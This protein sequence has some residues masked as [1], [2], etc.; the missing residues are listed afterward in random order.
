M[1]ILFATTCLTPLALLALSAPAR[2]ETLIETKRTDAVTTA[3]IKAGAPDDIRITAAGGLAP[4]SGTA[5]TINSNNKVSNQGAIQI[6]GANNANGILALAGTSGA[7]ASSGS[8]TIDET[9]VAVDTDKDG[10]L[11]GSFAT[12]TRR[13]GIRTAGA[14]TGSIA[15]TGT[16]T[17]E[18]N[19]SA[20]I[21]LGG[22]LTGSLETG[23]AITVTGDR[24]VGV[25]AGAVSGNVRLAGAITA[26]GLG[27]TGAALNG[28]IGGALVV[29]GSIVATGYRS[30]T[31]P[32]DVSKLDGDDLL[33][34]GPAL[35]IAGNVAGGVILAVPPRDLD[36]KEADEDK[37]GIPDA[38][39]GSAAITSHGAAAAVQIGATDRAITIGPV[40][41]STFGFVIDGNVAG[42]GVY[43]GVDARGLV[44]GGLGGAVT[45]AGGIAVN[46]NVKAVS[47]DSNATA[48]RIGS[49]ATAPEVRV[50]G[51]IEASGGGKAGATSTAIAVDS[52]ATVTTIRNSGMIKAGA[53]AAEGA[54]TAIVDRSGNLALVE[55]SGVIG[56][57]GAAAGRNI[58]IDLRANTTGAI[59]RQ[60]AGA[61]GAAAPS[62]TGDIYFGSGADTL[63]LGG[64]SSFTGNADF[65]GGAD[66]L[67]LTGGSRFTGS[68]AGAQGLA[69]SVGSGTLALT[70]KSSV[71][72]ASLA[73]GS[74]GVIGVNID[75]AGK[76]NT[77]FDVAGTA[78][79]DKG[80]QVA[81][82]LANVSNAEGKYVIVRAGALSGAA[83]LGTSATL[84]PF[85][86]KSS[87]AAGAPGE[88]VLDLARKSA[89]E[90]KLNR[91]QASAYEAVVKAL[92]SDAKVAGAFLDIADADRFGKTLRQMLPD[93][94]GGTFET[95]TQASRATA[96]MVADPNILTAGGEKLRFFVQ[97]V[98]WGTSNDLT[99]TSGYDVSGWGL[100]GGIEAA[101]P[102]GNFGV[103][104][105]L[106]FG[107]DA[108][109]GADNSVHSNQYELAA[110]WRGD[111]NGFQANARVSGAHVDFEGK[112]QFDGA[113]G[114]EAV[115]RQTTGNW[116]GQLWSASGGV[117]YEARFGRLSLRPIAA[118]D[119]YRLSES[120][121][122]ETGG[123]KAFDLTVKAR[124]SDELAASAT[125]AAG[126]DFGS[127]EADSWFRAEIEGGR[128]Q[129]I[130]GSLG[131]TTAH[132]GGSQDFTLTPEDRTNGWVG[133]IRAIGGNAMF[134][135]AG[136]FSAEEQQG[137]AAIAGRVSLILGL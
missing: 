100:G 14:F 82:T 74:E 12:G 107:S 111:W 110:Y 7:I 27:A 133:K 23:G 71:A 50:A 57:T 1:R 64:K 68:L 42:S 130:G 93:H 109:S 104:A 103:S 9:Y 98:A 76:T 86:F 30:V 44:I 119:Y 54:A 10:D 37:D 99:A 132:F 21:A 5:V 4:T 101:T 51:T 28:D 18:G 135:V 114:R 13:A 41:A 137:R 39:E 63:A 126:L 65:G 90:L 75:P 66:Q 43:K 69:V 115:Q 52:G 40:A 36:P 33:Q 123:G 58:A 16:I 92:D 61:T 108:D 118:I 96:R 80:A 116:N 25:S 102:A 84:L 24:S 112:R 72:I 87:I 45:I 26:Q 73:V 6:T 121:Y 2:T 136:E 122:T 67:N 3:T 120:G 124:T 48:V 11:D 22:P 70:G 32:A 78:S 113:I 46:G 131:A 47:L 49:G 89:T 91:S 29:Q 56:A 134:R 38:S 15:S 85:M 59:V 106:L 95:V 20:G 117:A 19:D 79:F 94:A 8:I 83:N 105:G 35:S 127:N 53:S 17:V 81:V 97:Q 62:I 31:A 55:N 34:G 88:V 77:R 129:L 60:I 128:R 125:L